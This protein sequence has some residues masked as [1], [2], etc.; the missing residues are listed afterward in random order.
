MIDYEMIGKRIRGKRLEKKMTQEKLAELTD[1][2]V[3]HISH[4]ETNN[5][6][7]SIKTFVAILNALGISAD[8]LLCD[9]L[10]NAAHV[11]RGKI[12]EEIEDMSE[13]E[14]RIVTDMIIALKA[15]LRRRK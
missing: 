8:E 2:G 6:I 14:I 5:T 4:I 15:S 12:A 10:D 1:V 9:S 3:T 11:Y 7:P 13:E